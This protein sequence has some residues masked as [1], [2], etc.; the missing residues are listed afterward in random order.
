MD[1]MCSSWTL[2][3]KKMCTGGNVSNAI[4]A[5]NIQTDILSVCFDNLPSLSTFNVALNRLQKEEQ[6]AF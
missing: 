4:N 3:H 1:G 2:N 6:T 5:A